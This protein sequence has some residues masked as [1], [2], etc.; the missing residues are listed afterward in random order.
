MTSTGNEW[1]SD[2]DDREGLMLSPVCQNDHDR[3]APPQSGGRSRG[4]ERE[5]GQRSV[6]SGAEQDLIPA[7]TVHPSF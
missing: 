6:Q 5:G 3:P 4:V 2:D 7:G 1:L